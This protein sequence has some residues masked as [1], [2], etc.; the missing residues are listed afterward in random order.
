[1]VS[2]TESANKLQQIGTDMGRSGKLLLVSPAQ[3]ILVSDS[4]VVH[5]SIF[6]LSKNFKCFGMGLAL[7]REGSLTALY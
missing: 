1:L 6:V 5:D 3:P 2:L 7:Q 4:V